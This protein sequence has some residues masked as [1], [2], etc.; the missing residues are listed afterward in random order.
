MTLNSD[1]PTKAPRRGGDAADVAASV[2]RR[3]NVR[4]TILGW[5]SMILWLLVAGGVAAYTWFFVT[6]VNPTL[7]YVAVHSR[8]LSEQGEEIRNHFF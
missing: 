6:Y 4:S 3:M 8:D 5:I 2:I 1:R 7:E